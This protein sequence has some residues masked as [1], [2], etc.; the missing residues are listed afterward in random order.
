MEAQKQNY[1]QWMLWMAVLIAG[2]LVLM[3]GITH[4]SLWY[5]ES[6]TGSLV[7]QSFGDIIRIT[8][9]DSHPPLYYLM[10]RAFRLVLG[11]TVFT[12]RVFSVLG[13][14][15][16]AGLG[17]GPVKR[18]AG[19]N[20]GFI[21]TLLVFCFPIT[22]AMAQEA[23]MYTWAAFFV[24]GS[25]LYGYLSYR[26]SRTKDL[27]PFALFSLAAMY[28][29][30]YA[31]LAVAVLCFLMLLG[32][33]I[34]RKKVLPYLIALTA[35]LIGYAPWTIALLGQVS[36][37]SEHFWIPPVTGQVIWQTLTYPFSSKFFD[38]A[39]PNFAA[40]SL[41]LSAGLIAWGLWQRLREKDGSVRLPLFALG[42]FLLTILG[43]VIASRL[44]RPVLVERYVV[45]LLGLLALGLAYGMAALEKKRYMT[46]ACA[47]IAA[48]S[49]LQILAIHAV[50]VNGPM[51]EAVAYLKDRIE[52]GDVFLHTDEHTLGTFSYYFPDHKN[53]YYQR[54]GYSGYSNYDAFKPNGITISSLDEVEGAPR[55]WLLQRPGAEDSH[56]SVTEWQRKGQMDV[57]GMNEF[58]LRYSWYAFTLYRATLMDSQAKPALAQSGS[59]T[60]TARAN[61]FR[62]N[63]GVAVAHL[64]NKGLMMN[65]PGIKN[66]GAAI[67]DGSA[68]FQFTGLPFGEYAVFV[69]HDENGNGRLD[70]EGGISLEGFGTSNNGTVSAGPP[71]FEESKF[72]FFKDG[73]AV[74]ITVYYFK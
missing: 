40:Q 39:S 32:M 51:T 45:P 27:I 7:N 43:G 56:Q 30:Y 33:L 60:L 37:V 71:G 74:D 61:H 69:F 64:F 49:L 53:Y 52:P 19:T 10:L 9:N 62:N 13:A 63:E 42:T 28:T 21:Y 12:L 55:I 44:I 65:L 68:E 72:E 70:T 66:L 47:L 54:S 14:L 20:A 23:R 31:L 35:I 34:E 11:N 41:Y 57:V 26:E 48:L 25:A 6:Y 46:L 4:E 50:R 8:A 24:T 73:K 1:R 29:H 36:R 16:L 17:I 2:A 22:H 67:K 3:I 5:D 58:R 18:A 38:L 15:F 59:G